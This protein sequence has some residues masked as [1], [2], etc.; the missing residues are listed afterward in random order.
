MA[1]QGGVTSVSS[2]SSNSNRSILAT[3]RHALFEVTPEP[4]AKVSALVPLVTSDGADS[5]A[6]EQV[7]RQ[8]LHEQLGPAVRELALQMAG[9]A[10]AVPEPALRKRAALR[11]LA[12]KGITA[13]A[14]LQELDGTLLALAAQNDAFAA[15]LALR[16]RALEQKERAATERYRTE[17]A[18]AEAAIARLQGELEAERKRVLEAGLNRDEVTLSCQQE[19]AELGSKQLGFERAHAA[20]RDE[21][22]ALKQQLSAEPV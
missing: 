1:S 7:L 6:A 17:T 8:A 10:E 2:Q 15:K 19:A 11:V 12:L 16:R 4:A 14:L 22:Q 18:E 21:Y 20:V 3:L 13:Q 9:L 5:A